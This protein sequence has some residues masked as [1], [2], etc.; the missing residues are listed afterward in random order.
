MFKS[1][2]IVQLQRLKK[3]TGLGLCF[4]NFYLVSYLWRKVHSLSWLS[5]GSSSTSI[6]ILSVTGYGARGW[7]CAYGLVT[8]FFYCIWL[9]QHNILIGYGPKPLLE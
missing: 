4:R 8:I 7:L 6:I 1:R 5:I 9:N 2:G 3:G